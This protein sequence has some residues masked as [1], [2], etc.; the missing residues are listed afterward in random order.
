MYPVS[1]TKLS[2]KRH[3]VYLSTCIRI[4][5]ARPGYLYPATRIWCKR[6]LSLTLPLGLYRKLTKCY[7]TDTTDTTNEMSMLLIFLYGCYTNLDD[8]ACQVLNDAL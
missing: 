5:F 2:L 1:A 8:N 4:Q 3:V 6:G 7:E